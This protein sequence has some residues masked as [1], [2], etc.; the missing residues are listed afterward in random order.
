MKE[1]IVKREKTVRMNGTRIWAVSIIAAFAAAVAVFG[2]MV[3]L[4]KDVLEQYE[5]GT[6]YTAV[7]KIPKGQVITDENYEQYFAEKELDVKCIPDTALYSPEQVQGFISCIDLETGTLLTQGMFETINEITKNMQEPVIA[8][9]KAEDMYQ[10]VGGVLRPGDRI[11]IYSVDEKENR[12]EE[13]S[14]KLIWTDVFVQEV[15]DQAGNII[16]GEDEE[17][18]AQRVNVYLDKSEVERFYSEL[19]A[20]S[21]RAVK[22]CE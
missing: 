6:I 15:F 4:E 1:K 17:A 9:F 14:A 12:E 21:L 18:V 19:A 5:K 8:G 16:P 2:V 20:G 10:V 22:V 3:K 13:L 7:K 11:H